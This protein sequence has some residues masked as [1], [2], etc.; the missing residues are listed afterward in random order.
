M[1][2]GE[3][4][5]FELIPSSN[6]GGKWT[7]FY[8]WNQGRTQV[9]CCD[10]RLSLLPVPWVRLQLLKCPGGELRT[11]YGDDA[12]ARAVADPARLFARLLLLLGPHARHSRLLSLRPY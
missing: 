2:R 9:R 11:V 3:T 10:F 5:K 1:L 12:S 8:L 4:H 6:A 7:A